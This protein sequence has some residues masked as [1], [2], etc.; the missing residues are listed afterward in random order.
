M[1]RIQVRDLAPPDPIQPAPLQSDTFQGAPQPVIDHDLAQLADSLGD[2]NKNIRARLDFS[3]AQ[4]KQTLQ[5]QHLAEFERWKAATSSE[6][7]LNAIRAGKLPLEDDPL[8]EAGVKKY[9]AGVLAQELSKN[10]DQEL[11]SAP[12]FGTSSFDPDAYVREKAKP[13]MDFLQGDNMSTAFFGNALDH[14]RSAV[15]GEQQKALGANQTAEIQDAA[16][17]QLDQAI[18]SGVENHLNPQ[19]ISDQL[20]GIYKAVGPR[21]SGSLGLKP[22]E[23]DQI[24]LQVLQ[25]K[26]K[27]PA[28]AA[29]VMGLLDAPRQDGET[30]I[31]ALS[32]SYRNAQAVQGIRSMA[33]KTLGDQKD[34]EVQQAAV[35]IAMQALQQGNGSFDTI[36]D[37]TLSNPVD[38]SR[39]IDLKAKDIKDQA[40]R[41]TLNQIRAQNG[42]QPDWDK[43]IGVF[44]R[45]NVKHPELVPYLSTVPGTSLDN[46]TQLD[47]VA[48]KGNLFDRISQYNRQYLVEH[49][50]EHALKFWDGYSALV[51]SGQSPQQAAQMVATIAASKT[52]SMSPH[53][54]GETRQAVADAVQGKVWGHWYDPTSWF[55]TNNITNQ[56]EMAQKINE[57]A[58]TVTKASGLAPEKAVEYASDRILGNAVRL[59]GR[60]IVS[61]GL[62]Q[63]DEKYIQPVLDRLYERNRAFYNAQGISSSDQI[64]LMPLGNGTFAAVAWDRPEFLVDQKRDSEGRVV[65]ATPVKI[66]LTDIQQVRKAMDTDSQ[67]RAMESAT[68]RFRGFP[69]RERGKYNPKDVPSP[70]GQPMM[71]NPFWG[72]KQ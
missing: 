44:V 12:G 49:L 6:D 4:A 63:G 40:A 19:Q 66:N 33:L 29:T 2:F 8:V 13:Y 14:V 17:A 55:D 56:N 24:L 69:N 27:D 3:Q 54:D 58:M 23:T 22:G 37:Q 62:Q 48:Q 45:N 65:A 39:T 26:A 70:Q 53:F 59:N 67:N 7:Q 43:E 30:T 31:P 72:G 11:P 42:G 28:Q 47:Q 71:N 10:I 46:P 52:D 35:G 15:L 68:E 16:W 60:A 64:S 61:P 36:T 20:R 9:K 50:P 34:Q 51:K 41:A 18:T 1:P 25:G 38:P 21:P 5:Q 32:K 57:L